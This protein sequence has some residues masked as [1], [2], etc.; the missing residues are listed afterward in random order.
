MSPTRRGWTFAAAPLP[1]P[2]PGVLPFLDACEA[3]EVRRLVERMG[4]LTEAAQDYRAYLAEREGRED[5]AC[6]V[7][8]RALE[9]CELE[10]I[11]LHR[12]IMPALIPNSGG[13]HA[14]TGS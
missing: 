8:L 7:V 14:R 12:Q 5:S 13:R 4:E 3:P 11:R 1:E 9:M 6:A 10:I 2:E